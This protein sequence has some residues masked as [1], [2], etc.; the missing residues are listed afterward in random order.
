MLATCT[1][2]KLIV[3]RKTRHMK[4]KKP[5]RMLRVES[6]KTFFWTIKI[7]SR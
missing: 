3:I 1:Q 2:N 5:K 6:G 7:L 4:L